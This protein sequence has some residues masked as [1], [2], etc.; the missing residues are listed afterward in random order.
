MITSELVVSKLASFHD[1]EL[2]GL[3]YQCVDNIAD[4]TSGHLLNLPNDGK[5]IDDL[6]IGETKLQDVLEA[7]ELILGH[8]DDLHL[9]TWDDLDRLR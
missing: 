4:I 5:S 9:L 1:P 6:L 7:K 8:G 3:T 2:E